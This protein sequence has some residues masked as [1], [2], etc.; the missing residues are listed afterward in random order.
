MPTI[1]IKPNDTPTPA[2]IAT[3]CEWLEFEELGA[4]EVGSTAG[5]KGI[6]AARLDARLGSGD[7]VALVNSEVRLDSRDDEADVAAGVNVEDAVA[8]D[9]TVIVEYG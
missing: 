3:S 4:L 9:T 1:A 7:E 2:P 6:L 5:E 8:A